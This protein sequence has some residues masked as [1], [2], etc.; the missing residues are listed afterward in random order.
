LVKQIFEPLITAIC[1]LVAGQ[2][3]KVR[4]KTMMA[5]DTKGTKIKVLFNLL[6]TSLSFSDN[7]IRT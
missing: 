2:V 3:V 4:I 5:N 1:V 6:D 7:G